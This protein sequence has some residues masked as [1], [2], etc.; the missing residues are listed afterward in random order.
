MGRKLTHISEARNWSPNITNLNEQLLLGPQREILE[1]IETINTR[2]NL[3]L[4]ATRTYRW[5]PGYMDKIKMWYRTDY[6]EE[7]MKRKIS[8]FFNKINEK[9]WKAGDSVRNGRL[10]GSPSPSS[11]GSCLPGLRSD[12]DRPRALQ[13][14]SPARAGSPG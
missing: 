13:D 11:S 9:S 2:W 6:V 1:I 7:H 3:D 14:L 10:R 8:T 5:G 12:R 4:N